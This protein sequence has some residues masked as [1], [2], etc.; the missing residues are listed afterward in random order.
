MVVFPKK[1]LADHFRLF[2]WCLS[3]GNY[4]LHGNAILQGF[5]R[6]FIGKDFVIVD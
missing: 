4:G 3:H 2:M 1:K 6:I 5:R